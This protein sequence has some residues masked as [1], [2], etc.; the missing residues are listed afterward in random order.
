[1]NRPMAISKNTIKWIKS[2]HQKKYRQKYNKF[3]AEGDKIVREMLQQERYPIRELYALASWIKIHEAELEQANFPIN[4]INDKE[5]AQITQLQTPNQVLVIAEKASP[6]VPSWKEG[7]TLFLDGL[8]DP[9]NLGTILRIAD[10]FGIAQVVAGPGT[11]E[12]FNSKVI[13]ATMGAFLRIHFLEMP[14]SEITQQ[15][16]DLPLFAAD[17]HGQNVFNRKF[18]SAGLLLIG[19]EGNGV[20]PENLAMA[21]HSIAIPAPANGGAESLNAAVATG[22]LCAVIRNQ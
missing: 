13:Q 15:A 19:N 18:P 1:M 3:I 11:V 22:I 4:A 10:W 5:L 16:P 14:L 7:W 21:H 8:Q 12:L 9:G 17:M 2:L 6:I 20:R